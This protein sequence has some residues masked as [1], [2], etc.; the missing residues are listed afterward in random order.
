MIII[1]SSDLLVGAE[2]SHPGGD[3]D[4]KGATHWGFYWLNHNSLEDIILLDYRP[5]RGRKG[6]DDLLKGF[7]GYL[8]ADR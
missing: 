2:G 3:R 4:K 5:R 8:Q 1:G 7:Q 6:P